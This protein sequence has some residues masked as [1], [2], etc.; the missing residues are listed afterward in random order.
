[1]PTTR[2][3]IE[4][5]EIPSRPGAAGWDEFIAMA[6]VRN[7]AEAESYRTHDLAM[8]A[9]ELLP[10]WQNLAH[11]PKRLLVAR[12]SGGEIVGIA[13]YE[14]Q[15]EPSDVAWLLV[16]V[17]PGWR[18]RGIGTALADR[19]E[20]IARAERRTTQIVYSV[21]PDGPGA[22]VRAPT[23]F[24]SVPQGN[25]EVRFLL[26]R[27]YRL[28]QVERGSRLTLPVDEGSLRNLHAAAAAAA[29][30]DYALRFWVDRV[31]PGWRGDLA[32]LYTRMST[33]APTAGLAEPEDVWSV[34]RLLAHE[35]AHASAPRTT[36]TAAVEHLPSGRLAG[37]TE[38]W[39]PAETH[40]AV[41]QE[42]T[43]VLREHRGHRLGMLLKVANLQQLG[44]ARP[45]HP[46]IITFNAEENRPML[47]VNEA[48]GFVPMGY[49]GAWRRTA[50]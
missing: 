23:G 31:P 38:L 3:T 5:P 8:S 37:F 17:L 15:P 36:L 48:M 11:E 49:E 28:E 20:A 7:A 18:R 47:D 35:E 46:S 40:R 26:A 4:E 21:S 33:D 44:R 32:H 42:D 14:T 27:G 9:E 50:G 25:P 19:L 41:H 16:Q 34:Q 6:A 30:P 10:A 12:A 22:R 39:V 45:G 29:G 2:F 1:M 13:V 24:G 43:L